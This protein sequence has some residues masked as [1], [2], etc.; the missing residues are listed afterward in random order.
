MRPRKLEPDRAVCSPLRLPMRDPPL[1]I[2]GQGLAGTALAWQCWERAVPFIVVDRDAPITSSKIAAGLISPITGFRL[3]HAPGYD[4]MLAEALRTYRALERKLG[5]RVLHAMPHLR[6]LA[7]EEEVQFWLRRRDQLKFWREARFDS[8]RFANPRGAFMMKHAG[9][10]DTAAFLAASKAFFIAQGCWQAG[11][12]SEP[13]LTCTPDS[14]VWADQPYRAAVFCTGWEAARSQWFEWVKFQSFRGTILEARA[15]LGGERRIVHADCWLLPQAH[16]RMRIGATFERSFTDPHGVD[17]AALD[18]LH[19]RVRR[20][21]RVPYA[22]ISQ[23]SAVRPVIT[24]QRT[25]IGTHP[26]RPRIGFFN[27]LASKGVLRAP[28]YARLLADHLLDGA[29]LPASCD[30]RNY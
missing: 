25:F 30:V 23:Q 12:V 28:Y 20:V 3:T 9:W 10:M 5:L 7:S 2:I 22:V 13:D 1:L 6:F 24:G 8:E 17:E 16:G 18:D 4:A 27:G 19:T 15:D 26:A 14:V 29:A 21:L 11:A